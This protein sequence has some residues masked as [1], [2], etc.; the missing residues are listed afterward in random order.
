MMNIGSRIVAV[1][2]AMLLMAGCLRDQGYF[3]NL[4]ISGY[5]R[6]APDSSAI[7]GAL[8]ILD[9]YG[10]SSTTDSIGY[11]DCRVTVNVGQ[12]PLDVLVTVTDIDG[13]AN[14]IF[15][16]QDTLIYDENPDLQQSIYYEIDFYVEIVGD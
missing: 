4:Y 9:K 14:G 15:V 10:I 1:V 5:V 16:S 7:P 8:V 12:Y 11:Y 13:E 3:N 2:L 6:A